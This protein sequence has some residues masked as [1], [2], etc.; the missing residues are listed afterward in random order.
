[1]TTPGPASGVADGSA[2][3][4]LLSG[5]RL[6]QSISVAATLGVADALANGPR[7]IEDIAAELDADAGSL[8]RLLRALAAAGVFVEDD[9]RSFSL[10]DLGRGL[11][12]DVDGSVRDQAINFGRPYALEAWG[13][14]EH[15][16]RTGEN[17]FAAL[18]GEDDWTWRTRDATENAIFNRAMAS[19]SR[20]VGPALAAAYDF[21]SARIVADIG[22]GTGSLLAAV[23]GANAGVRGIV[24]DQP[25]VVASAGPVLSAVGVADRCEIVGG[26]FFDSVPNA[27]V[28]ILKSILHDW[29]NPE[30]IKILQSIRRAASPSSRLLV[31][32]VVL[33]PPN[34]D[35]AGKLMDLNMLVMP[36]GRERTLPE[37]RALL[38]DGGFMLASAKPLSGNFQLLEVTVRGEG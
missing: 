9:D 32:E 6:A 12:S 30:S 1:M 35:L 17:A 26:N 11:R 5:T 4:Q 27:D 3:R 23:L 28:F 36:G 13:N 38:T 19:V 24:F 29:P 21:S 22:G 20:P 14:L 37:W 25:H 7:S 31:I 2:L 8:Y 18:H 15:S 33:G 16:I 10:T 34:E